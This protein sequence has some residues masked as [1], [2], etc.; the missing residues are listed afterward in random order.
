MCVR[1]CVGVLE[2]ESVFVCE[3]KRERLSEKKN[4]AGVYVFREQDANVCTVWASFQNGCFLLFHHLI[5][6]FFY[7]GIFRLYFC[8]LLYFNKLLIAVII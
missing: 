8:Y 7:L 1:M 2:C 6:T 3:H 4:C 5:A